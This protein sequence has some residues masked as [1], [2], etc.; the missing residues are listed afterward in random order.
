MARRKLSDREAIT[1]WHLRTFDP[2]GKRKD[3]YDTPLVYRASGKGRGQFL[4]RYY[5]ADGDR[6]RYRTLTIGG[7][8]G[9]T[10][11]AARARALELQDKVAAGEDPAVGIRQTAA[12]VKERNFKKLARIY[13]NRHADTLRTGNEIRRA[14]KARVFPHFGHRNLDEI[15]RLEV[16]E[17]LHSIVAEGNPVLAN[18]IL[19]YIRKMFNWL[20]DNGLAEQNPAHKIPLPGGREQ[21]RDRILSNDEINAI[22]KSCENSFGAIVKI[23]LLTGQRRGSIAHMRWTDVDFKKSSWTGPAVNMK[24][25][26][27]HELPLSTQALAVL[28][29]LPRS[30]EYVFGKTGAQPYSGFSRALKYL[31]VA[32]ETFGWSLHD[33]R[34]TST[35]LMAEMGVADN[36]LR[37]I[38]DHAPP[39]NDMLGRVYNRHNYKNEARAALD[40]LGLKIDSIVNGGG[41]RVVTLEFLAPRNLLDDLDAVS[42]HPVVDR[43]ELG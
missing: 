21:P 11:N 42:L 34:R 38:L 8:P 29:A 23:A 10:L 31:H 4:F 24:Q 6:K 43:L 17:F 9:M 30:G 18:R 2:K 40:A 27:P 36:I 19:A 13:L 41:S 14:F 35:S 15:T 26:R 25:K 12:A 37:K 16:S 20:V 28:S 1:G 22:W 32:S 39:T 7:N 5:V 33:C 3:F